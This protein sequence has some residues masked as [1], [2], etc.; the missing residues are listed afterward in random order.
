VSCAGP[1]QFVKLGVA[2]LRVVL[3]GSVT[4]SFADAVANLQHD[5]LCST[6]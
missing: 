2:H 5:R 6:G 3:L 4:V 1:L